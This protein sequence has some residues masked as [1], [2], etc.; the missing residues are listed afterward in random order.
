MFSHVSVHPSIH[1]SIHPSVCPQGGGTPPGQVG[2]GVPQPGP[3][4]GYPTSDTPPRQTSTPAGGYPT[5]DTPPRQTSTPCG[6][7]PTLGT[8]PPSDLVGG[9]PARGVP[10]LGLRYH[11]QTWLGGTTPRVPPP[12]HQTWPWGVP[13]PPPPPCN[14]WST[15][16]DAG[17]VSCNNYLCS[18]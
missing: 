13:P 6:G 15:C 9:T 3:A 5:S 8:P 2:A 16:V 18:L 10:H 4:G 14:K 7:Y 17:G 12:P 1:P 11:P